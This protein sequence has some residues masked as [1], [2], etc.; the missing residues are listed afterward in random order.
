MATEA[1]FS[2]KVKE[3]ENEAP[4]ITSFITTPEFN[5]LTKLSFDARMTVEHKK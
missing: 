2:T 4:Y 3:I 5:R 1:A